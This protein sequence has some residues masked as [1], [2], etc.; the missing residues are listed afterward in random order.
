MKMAASTPASAQVEKWLPTWEPGNDEARNVAI[1]ND[2]KIVV[3]GFSFNA[4]GNTDFAVMRYAADGS[5][6]RF[7]W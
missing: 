5:L 1:Q 6:D 3:T 4:S 7:L 2:G